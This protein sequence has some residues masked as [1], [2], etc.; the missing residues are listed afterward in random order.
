MEERYPSRIVENSYG[1]A[2]VAEGE[3]AAGV[4]VARFDGPRVKTADVP[5]AE[6][7]YVLWMD[8]DDWM[9]PQTSARFV[10]HSCTPN[11]KVND[12]LQVYTTRSVAAGEELTFAYNHVYPGEVPPDWDPR[13]SFRCCCGAAR[14]QGEVNG[15]RETAAR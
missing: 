13:W 8:G 7:C 6:V 1:R 4:V 10:N 9:I 14:C 2:L 3:L 11:C 5:E 15:W 12:D